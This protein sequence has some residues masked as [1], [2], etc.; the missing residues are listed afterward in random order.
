MYG[1]VS[2]SLKG[3]AHCALYLCSIPDPNS[4]GYDFSWFIVALKLP[5][6]FIGNTTL[7]N[8]DISSGKQSFFARE[9]CN[10]SL[11]DTSIL[12]TTILQFYAFL[13]RREGSQS[14]PF[15]PQS[16]KTVVLSRYFGVGF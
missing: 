5:Y 10:F 16:T 6:V 8:G 12:E 9:F 7:N 2:S 14:L 11:F 4:C 3:A 1:Y 15:F 13:S